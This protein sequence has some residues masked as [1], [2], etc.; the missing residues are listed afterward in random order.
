ME[1]KF[2]FY[3]EPRSVSGTLKSIQKTEATY[4]CGLRAPRADSGSSRHEE[5]GVGAEPGGIEA[6]MSSE[7]A[8]S[9]VTAA[10]HD[11]RRA[12]GS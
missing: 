11:D 6:I 1:Y 3:G 9:V 8:G 12:S 4:D 7:E 5:C 2:Y 10:F